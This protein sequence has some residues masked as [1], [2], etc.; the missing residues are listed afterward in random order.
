MLSPAEL[1]SRAK[2][3]RA[4]MSPC[5][6]CPR[7][8][9]VD[10][11]KGETG[12]CRLGAEMMVYCTNLHPGEEPPISG[13]GGSGTVFFTGCNLG[14]AFCQNFTF[15]QLMNGKA[16]T[17]GTLAADM[18]ALQRRGAHN[19]N[20]VTPTPHTALAVEA[21]AIARERGLAIPLVYNCSGYESPEVLTLLDGIVDIYL[22]D[23]KYAG[24]EPARLL[25][26]A[27]DYPEANRIALKEMW[28]QT[29]PL[30]LDEHG[31]ARR[32]MII[33]HLVLPN[34]LAGTR[35]VLQFIARELGTS[36]TVSLM[37]QYYP[38]HRAHTIPSINRP[39]TWDEYHEALEWYDES[40][41]KDGYIQEWTDEEHD[42]GADFFKH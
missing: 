4:L 38:M 19:I 6:L 1:F 25:S 22:P 30:E 16:A 33:R 31:V 3:L 13:S 37:R 7:K 41:L 42:D 15:S 32:G 35:G 12:F 40:G 2:A 21:L 8:C 29:G 39:I 10:R 23:A 11:L 24:S 17:P 9:R 34:R 28:R 26:S 5:M 36:A 20:W 27:P 18:L 14:C